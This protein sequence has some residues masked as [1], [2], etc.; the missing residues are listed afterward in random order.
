MEAVGRDGARA[1]AAPRPHGDPLGFRVMDE[2]PDDQVIVDIPHPADHADLILQPLSVFLRLPGIPLQKAVHAQPAEIFLVGKALRNRK[3]RQM[4]LI[5][6]ELHIATLGN[7]GG[8]LKGLRHIGKPLP[9]LVLALDVEFLRLE[10][11]PGRIVHGLARLHRQKHVLSLRILPA[12]IV[13]VVGHHQGQPRLPGQAHNA[14]VGRPLFLDIVILK[15]Q[16]KM[17]RPEDLRQLQR[18]L[19]RALI[20]LG[21]Q[22]P[23]NRTGQTGGQADQSPGMLPEQREVDPGLPVKAVQ[24]PSGY[25]TAQIL[26]PLHIFAEQDH[27]V[28]LVVHAI[29]PVRHGAGRHIDLAADDRLHPGGLRRLVKI[30]HAVHVAVIR[31]GDGGLAKLFDPVH[32]PAD[33]AGPVQK[34]VL[35]MNM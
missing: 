25:K 8:I 17:V 29:H 12:E 4:V 20:I 14:L 22:Q 34:A 1:G 15:L 24:I 23:G 33:A 6:H 26:I 9:E 11:H 27:M 30:D 28:G 18:V 10:A 21:Q 35:R 2:I 13:G 31:N 19:L 3:R 16:I 32:Q 7:A 5:E